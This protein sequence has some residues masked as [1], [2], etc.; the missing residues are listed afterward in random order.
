MLIKALWTTWRKKSREA[1]LRQRQAAPPLTQTW[2]QGS[3]WWELSWDSRRGSFHNILNKEP[4][5]SPLNH[6]G[7][8]KWTQLSISRIWV[9]IQF[10]LLTNYVTSR[11]RLFLKPQFPKQKTQHCG[12]IWARATTV[13]PVRTFSQCRCLINVCACL[14]GIHAC[15]CVWIRTSKSISSS[16]DCKTPSTGHTCLPNTIP[17]SSSEPFSLQGTGP[18][19]VLEHHTHASLMTSPALPHPRLPLPAGDTQGMLARPLSDPWGHPSSSSPASSASL[20]SSPPPWERE[21]FPAVYL[22]GSRLICRTRF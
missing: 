2:E 12:I 13:L 7:V 22:R 5:D 17:H 3:V 21:D 9:W 14:R 19:S 1:C 20:G 11:R 8:V 18:F 6:H 16:G 4:Q 15:M 10:S